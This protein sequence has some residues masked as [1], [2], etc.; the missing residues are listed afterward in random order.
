[1]VR[2]FTSHVTS[3]ILS[4]LGR[5]VFML[6][7]PTISQNDAHFANRVNR[8]QRDVVTMA[9]TDVVRVAVKISSTWKN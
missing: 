2:P 9:V 4:S 8:Y 7:S 1:M 3:M 5:V 6:Q